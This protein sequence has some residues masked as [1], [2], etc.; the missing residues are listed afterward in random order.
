MS[1]AGVLL[2][3][4]S[5]WAARASCSQ[6]DSRTMS[7]LCSHPE[8]SIPPML[9]TSN[10]IVSVVPIQN[11]SRMLR[12][13]MSSSSGAP[14]A[15]VRGSR[16]M[17]QMGHGPG[18]SETTS[19][20][21]GQTYSVFALTSSGSR[22]IPHLRH[23]PGLLEVTPGSIGQK[24]LGDALDRVAGAL[25]LAGGACPSCT[26]PAG[27]FLDRYLSASAPNFSAQ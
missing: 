14:A 10:G 25:G 17:P 27:M 1:S 21:I 20:C 5:T 18:L 6:A 2:M 4:A 13:S 23:E 12:S 9:I 11:R 3:C 8:V 24:Y 16:A 15:V 22:A 19:G 26:N 7:N